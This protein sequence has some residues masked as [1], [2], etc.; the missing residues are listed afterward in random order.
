[1][2]PL[3]LGSESILAVCADKPAQAGFLLPACATA[4]QILLLSYSRMGV[5]PIQKVA[6]FAY[7]ACTASCREASNANKRDNNA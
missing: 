3:N 4:G 6:G 2:P 7:Y 1:M 5:A